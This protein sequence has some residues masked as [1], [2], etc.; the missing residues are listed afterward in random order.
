MAANEDNLNSPAGEPAAGMGTGSDSG[1]P[2]DHLA[3]VS[4]GP[5]DLRVLAELESDGEPDVV[6]RWRNHLKRFERWKTTRCSRVPSAAR[7]P[8]PIRPGTIRTT[9][10][11]RLRSDSCA[12]IMLAP[13][14][15]DG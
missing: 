11:S 13:N 2:G 7:S 1:A 5:E 12:A 9:R 14:L 6:V 15:S 4:L 8:M 3:P 10:R